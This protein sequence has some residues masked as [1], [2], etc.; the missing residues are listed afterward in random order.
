LVIEEFLLDVWEGIPASTD[1]V[2]NSLQRFRSEFEAIVY[3]LKEQHEQEGQ[4]M[5]LLTGQ[6]KELH[7]REGRTIDRMVDKLAYL[8]TIE[9]AAGDTAT[10]A[11]VIEP[12]VRHLREF[13]KEI[14]DEDDSS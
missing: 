12:L 9:I 5:D 6:W 1:S 3:R 10:R 2:A 13:L 11:T 7:D 4:K 14:G 8:K